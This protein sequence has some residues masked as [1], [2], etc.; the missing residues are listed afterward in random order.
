M[1]A[2]DQAE[3]RRAIQLEDPV[4][5]LV[6]ADQHDRLPAVHGEAAVDPLQ[7]ALRLLLQRLVRGQLAARRRRDLEECQSPAPLR[8]FLEQTLER[9]EALQDALG[10]VPALDADADAQV[11][12][13]AQALHDRGTRLLRRDARGQPAWRPLDR[14]RVWLDAADVAL[15]RHRHVLLV[16]LALD[17]AVDRGEEILAVVARVKAQDVRA[18]HVRQDLALPWA[19]AEG[20][21]I[22][23]GNVPEQRDGGFH[24][25][26]TQQPGQQ[27]EVEILDQDHGLGAGRFLRDHFREPGVDRLVVPPVF[28]AERRPHVRQVA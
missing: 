9:E 5:L 12:A 17:E 19:H 14:D 7:F 20:F 25:A 21:G 28:F 6:L 10:E 26:I 1:Q 24:A 11:A 16:D 22:G 23:P 2:V 27:C 13:Q 8:V 4:R 15:V 3:V 18:Q